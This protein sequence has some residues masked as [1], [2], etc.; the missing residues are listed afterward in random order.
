MQGTEKPQEVIA[1]DPA[2]RWFLLLAITISWCGV[3]GWSV[4]Q[5]PAA[6]ERPEAQRG[7]SEVTLPLPRPDDLEPT[8]ETRKLCG[9]AG[10][11][12]TR[13]PPIS[14]IDGCGIDVPVRVD[15]IAGVAIE[16]E[17]IASCKMVAALQSWIA[18]VA[19]PA[20]RHRGQE[21]EGVRVVASYVCRNVNSAEDGELS[22]HAL[23][24]AID[25]A[26]FQT[27]KGELSVREDWSNGGLLKD[28]YGGAC[29]IFGTT[30]GPEA[31]ALHEDH[32]HFDVAERRTSYCR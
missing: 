21:L 26:G 24:G 13:L 28:V 20:F 25:I 6:S 30:L 15:Q 27:S 1:G 2:T 31:D 19:K 23:G 10:V 16:P 4:A 17:A 12:G 9:F 18:D 5:A 14:D 29:G 8:Y 32:F 22:E 11:M 3:P 7:V